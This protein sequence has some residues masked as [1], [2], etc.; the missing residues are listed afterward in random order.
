MAIPAS[1]I[2]EVFPRVGTGVYVVPA[3]EFQR[4][5]EHAQQPFAAFAPAQV[6]QLLLGLLAQALHAGVAVDRKRKGTAVGLHPAASGGE[7]EGG[8]DDG[9]YLLGQ[10]ADFQ[11]IPLRE[12]VA[13]RQPLHPVQRLVRIARAYEKFVRLHALPPK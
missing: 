12:A 13:G 4:A 2:V 6:Q 11:H 1:H 10:Q 9:E 7:G 3:Q 5:A 8:A